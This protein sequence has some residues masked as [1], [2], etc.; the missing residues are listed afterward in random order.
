M[1]TVDAYKKEISEI[2][3][4]DDKRIFI[5]K[6]F[7]HGIPMVFDNRE[8]DYYHFRKRIADQFK[9]N[10]YEV[11]IVG[12][13][14]FGFSPFRFTDF[15]YNSDIDVV[16]FNEKLFD[17][18]HNLISDYQYKIRTQEILLTTDQYRKYIKF[19]KY[20]VM[21]W[22]RPDL[23]PK[24]TTEF[25][26][27]KKEWDDFFKSISHSKSEVG[28]YIVKAGLFKSH[29]FAEKYYSSSIEEVSNTIKSITNV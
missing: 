13:S 17:N 26:E 28:N 25:K 15:T 7:F 23:L 16:L 29:Q 12:S 27:L 10:F 21:G 8:N 19:L 18:F 5:Q 14:K 2:V 9:I 24:N 22:M 11:M 4:D 1:V 6:H 3:S 20:F